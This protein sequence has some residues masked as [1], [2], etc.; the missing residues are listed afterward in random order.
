M[1]NKLGK[2][3]LAYPSKPRIVGSYAIAGEKEGKGPMAKWF[4]LILE[5]DTYGEKTWEKIR[6]Q[7]AKTGI[8]AR[9]A[10][11]RTG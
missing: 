8:T 5:D 7:N 6:K 9:T 4:D 1:K 2:Q 10:K 11:I 3:T